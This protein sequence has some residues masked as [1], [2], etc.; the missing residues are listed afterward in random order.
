MYWLLLLRLSQ[1]CKCNVCHIFTRRS[2]YVHHSELTAWPTYH[3]H[4]RP[5]LYYKFIVESVLTE[6]FKIAQ[7]LAKLWIPSSALCAGAL[8]CWKMKNSLEIWR[9]AGRNCCNSITLR[10]ILGN[11]DFVID[12][13]QTGVM[14]TTCYSPTDAISDWTLCTQALCHDVFLLDWWIC[15]QLQVFR[16]GHCKYIFVS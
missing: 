8:Y 2:R 16:C 14:S 12:N 1:V 6:F 4:Q 3:H 11:P 13:C 7:H 15:V 9:M 5:L 10:I